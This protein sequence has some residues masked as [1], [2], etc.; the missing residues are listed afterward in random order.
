MWLS[1]KNI[2]I[3][4]PFKKLD[5]RIIGAFRNIG[6]KSIL[7]ELQLLQTVKIHNVFYPNFLQKA[8]TDALTAQVNKT[9]LLVI[10]SNE[11][12]WEL[13]DIFDARS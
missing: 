8:L 2:R 3:D 11:K 5:H 13:K 12:E 9:A 10:I 4:Q 1:T 7:L 6:K